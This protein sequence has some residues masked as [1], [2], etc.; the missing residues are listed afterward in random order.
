[1]KLATRLIT[2]YIACTLKD[3]HGKLALVE[4]SELISVRI[5]EWERR[6]QGTPQLKVV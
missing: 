5:S 2:Q 6:R 1:M 3:Q 4:V